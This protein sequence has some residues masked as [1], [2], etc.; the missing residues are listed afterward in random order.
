[1][2]Q[3][4]EGNEQ[5]VQMVDESD[6]DGIDFAQSALPLGVRLARK[7]DEGPV[8]ALDAQDW[9]VLRKL[10]TMPIQIYETGERVRAV[11]ESNALQMLARWAGAAVKWYARSE[12]IARGQ[13][14]EP[15]TE[16]PKR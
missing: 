13:A 3:A 16:E 12:T 7:E 11:D 5:V 15:W 4:S 8:L 1:M 14:V 2:G 10:L 9:A 6:L